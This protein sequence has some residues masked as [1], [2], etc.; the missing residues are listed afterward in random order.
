MLKRVNLTS[1]REILGLAAAIVAVGGGAIAFYRGMA[2]LY[3][4]TV[5]SRRT[6]GWQLYRLAA[7]ALWVTTRWVEDRLGTPA[8]AREFRALDGARE[9]VYHAGAPG[10]SRHA[11]AESAK[12]AY[13]NILHAHVVLSSVTGPSRAWRRPAMT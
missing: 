7:G 9:L 8:F 11:G 2:Q 4:Q 1:A 3:P 10:S 12:A 13:R 6:L 5:G